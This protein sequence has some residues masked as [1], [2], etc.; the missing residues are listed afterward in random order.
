MNV[1]TMPAPQR[2]QRGTKM[3]EPE[4]P[5]I[6]FIGLG[7]MGSRLAWRLA[8]AGLPL[9]VYDADQAAM[10]RFQATRVRRS[11]SPEA[12]VVDCPIVVAALPSSRVSREVIRAARP[13]A[14]T[15]VID[16]SNG[17]PEEVR[18]FGAWLAERDVAL[19]DAA[20]SGGLE[21]AALGHLLVQVGGEIADVERA[22]PILDHLAER[23]VHCGPLGS[24][25]AMRALNSLL[26]AANYAATIEALQ[27]GKRF[28]LDLDLMLDVF[29][30]STGAN[31][32]TAAE[33]APYVLTGR[34]NSGMTLEQLT[35]EVATALAMAQATK[36]EV[37]LSR[38]AGELWRMAEAGLEPGADH[39]ALA[40][41]YEH[42]SGTRLR[43]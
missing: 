24:G 41:W 42:R 20:L 19:I 21:R 31:H 8:E 1:P 29:N 25:L 6:A 16:T 30:S 35:A 28:G 7:R 18:S 22:R 34:F 4:T 13:V 27:I 17:T 3:K 36:T 37:P 23:I 15:L 14:G 33:I 5:R 9:A 43:R 11:R 32:A 10:D 2:E 40:R 26:A 12:V 38:V 39:T